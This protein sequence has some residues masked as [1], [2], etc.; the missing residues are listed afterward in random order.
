VRLAFYGEDRVVGLDAP[1]RG[2]RC[3]FLRRPDGTVGWLRIGGRLLVR[4]A[5]PSLSRREAPAMLQAWLSRAP[6]GR[7]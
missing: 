2:L 5:P 3:D 7:G 4:A 1:L 6:A